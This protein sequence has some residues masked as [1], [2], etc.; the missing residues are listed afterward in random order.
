MLFKYSST[1]QSSFSQS[2]CDDSYRSSPW[3]W[4]TDQ[5]I[6]DEWSA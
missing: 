5:P 4:T 3:G 2:H 1:I 6:L